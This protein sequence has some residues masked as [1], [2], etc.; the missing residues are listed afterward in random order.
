MP[1]QR[2]DPRFVFPDDHPVRL[3]RIAIC[4]ACPLSTLDT[5]L[6]GLLQGLV[7]EKRRQCTVCH[8]FVHIKSR[9]PMFHCPKG[10]W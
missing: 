2:V 9:F 3:Q 10:F 5:G 1:P 4:Q 6:A 8:C 7:G